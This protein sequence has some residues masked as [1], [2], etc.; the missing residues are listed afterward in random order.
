MTDTTLI[1]FVD[2]TGIEHEI[3]FEALAG[4]GTNEGIDW[5]ENRT[6]LS[7]QELKPI[8]EQLATYIG[9]PVVL[10]GGPHRD[11]SVGILT[12]VDL[13]EYEF[14]DGYMIHASIDYVAGHFAEKTDEPFDPWLDAWRI[15]VISDETP[16]QLREKFTAYVREQLEY[17]ESNTLSDPGAMSH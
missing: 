12:S 1:T 13:D 7:K 3:E 11:E 15:S 10:D 4:R 17:T 9:T 16:N 14:G 5:G 8:R 6:P 2:E